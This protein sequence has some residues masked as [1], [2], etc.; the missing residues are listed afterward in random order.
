MMFQITNCSKKMHKQIKNDS[1]HHLQHEPLSNDSNKPTS[2]VMIV[3]IGFSLA[4]YVCQENIHFFL[5]FSLAQGFICATRTS[6]FV[7][8][9]SPTSRGSVR[10]R[11]RKQKASFN[12]TDGGHIISYKYIHI[13]ILYL[14]RV[15]HPQG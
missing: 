3:R 5:L 6:T 9:I 14:T 7:T 8:R 4:F 11:T 1:T 2:G 13:Y 12:T 15:A 10:T